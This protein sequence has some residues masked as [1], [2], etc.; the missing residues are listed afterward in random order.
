MASQIRVCL[1]GSRAAGKTTFLAGLAVAKDPTRPDCVEVRASGDTKYD[2]DAFAATLRDGRW[3]P[4][5]NRLIEYSLD[6][7]TTGVWI[8]LHVLDY[9]GD[10][11]TDLMALDTD[12]KK[13]IEAHL[14]E[15][16]VL[17]LLVD[18]DTDLRPDPDDPN[19]S[20]QIKR[21]NALL[22]AARGRTDNP[23]SKR[24]STPVDIALVLTKADR[25]PELVDISAAE[26]FVNQVLPG[27]LPNL[28][29]AAGGRI[30]VFPLSA[31]GRTRE[32][33]DGHGRVPAPPL[34]PR[35][36]RELFA[37]VVAQRLRRKR[38]LVAT[39]FGIFLG[40]VIVVT[41]VIMGT[42]AS[43]DRIGLAILENPNLSV[44]DRLTQTANAGESLVQKRV[45]LA[46][47]EFSRYRTRISNTERT[48]DTNELRRIVKEVKDL[49]DCL[50]ERLRSE[51]AELDSE[52]HNRLA[53]IL[54]AAAD[55]QYQLEPA[56]IKA[57]ELLTAWLGEFP[58]RPEAAKVRSMLNAQIEVEQGNEKRA[59]QAIAVT[60]PEQ[61]REKADRFERYLQKY[62]MR[63]GDQALQLERVI[64]LA[65][66]FSTKNT[67]SVTLHSS[68]TFTASRRHRVKVHVGNE[69][70]IHGKNDDRVTTK[71]WDGATE[72]VPWQVGVPIKVEFGIVRQ[73]VLYT[74]DVTMATLTDDGPFALLALV[75]SIE[76]TPTSDG[77]D[78]F[79]DQ[80]RITFSIAGFTSQDVK[81]VK[82]Y[83][84][85]GTDW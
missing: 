74:T 19:A 28:K 5:T 49:R 6:I 21:L 24:R 37:W 36:Y 32:S 79:V 80:P 2:M 58:E 4:P 31:V 84:Q 78:G 62:R 45:D 46:C 47:E 48:N 18:P 57:K 11:A 81:W 56:G 14:A 68:G 73:Y 12:E 22:D 1:F 72:N 8:D 29:K 70:L 38:Q 50:P 25:Y 42:R 13:A 71:T 63:M 9:S 69:L 82:Q 3:P 34:A 44:R 61:L 83:L 59:I 77:D 53:S 64:A 51:S 26:S 39:G 43:R 23:E 17:L 66:L 67:F 33:E 60:S 54:F 65:R 10:L 35:G 52:L 76:L 30:A 16:S 75:D 41:T 40:L 55:S 27:L 7:A 20:V 15:A 85:P